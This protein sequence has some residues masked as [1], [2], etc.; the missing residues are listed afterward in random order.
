MK[1]KTLYLLIIGS[2][3]MTVFARLG[4]YSGEDCYSLSKKRCKLNPECSYDRDF[5]EC[6]PSSEFPSDEDLDEIDEGGEL[7]ALEPPNPDMEP[8]DGWNRMK[9]E[10]AYGSGMHKACAC[11][12]P[13]PAWFS[14]DGGFWCRCI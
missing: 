14:W 6:L 8:P 3:S 7:E 2:L 10:R 1:S 13:L 9:R 4:D 12:V 5:K 11:L